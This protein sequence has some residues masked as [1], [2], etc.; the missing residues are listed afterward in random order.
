MIERGTPTGWNKC[1]RPWSDAVGGSINTLLRILHYPPLDINAEGEAVR[2]AAHEDINFLTLLPSA[3]EPG[4]QVKDHDGNWHD[5]SVTEPNSIIVNVGDMLKEASGGFYKS[6]TH[7][8]VNPDGSANVARYSIPLFLHAS[9]NT[10][11]SPRYTAHEY[12]M[13]RLKELGLI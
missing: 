4:L 3:T 7:R 11:L 10:R 12:L 8:V 1:D 5:V 2:A 6:T 9:P 13:E